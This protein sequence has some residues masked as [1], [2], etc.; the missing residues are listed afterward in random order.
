MSRNLCTHPFQTAL[1]RTHSKNRFWKRNV[2]IKD[3]QKDQLLSKD[4]ENDLL[5]WKFKWGFPIKFRM[6]LKW[7]ALFKVSAYTRSIYPYKD[8]NSPMRINHHQCTKYAACYWKYYC[9]LW[10]LILYWSKDYT[11]YDVSYSKNGWLFL[12]LFVSDFLLK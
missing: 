11:K 12:N 1:L 2:R 5:S 9:N 4:D 7:G 10:L 3:M 8:C 6:C